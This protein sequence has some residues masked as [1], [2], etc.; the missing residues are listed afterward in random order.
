MSNA[1]RRFKNE[2]GDSCSD[3]N[4]IS[5]ATWYLVILSL[6]SRLLLLLSSCY[7]LLAT[8]FQCRTLNFDWWMKKWGFVCWLKWHFCRYLVPC[9]WYF[10][11]W[12]LATWYWLLDTFFQCRTLNSDWWMKK[13]EFVCL[14]KWHFGRYLVPCTWYFVQWSL[15]TWY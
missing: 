7:L 3:S 15:A 13:W 2:E 8:F 1:E 12:S 10:V 6:V 14:L 11:Q 4:G 9:T 5:E